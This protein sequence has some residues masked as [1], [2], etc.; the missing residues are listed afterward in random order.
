MGNPGVPGC[1]GWP[2][3]K[4]GVFASGSVGG[5]VVKVRG[6]GPVGGPVV[7][8]CASGPVGGPVAKV[9]ASGLVGG[10][11]AR[12]GDCGFACRHMVKAGFSD[13]AG[14]SGA[15]PGDGTCGPPQPVASPAH[16][17]VCPPP[18]TAAP[19][20]SALGASAPGGGPKM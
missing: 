14:P 18:G 2:M 11:L 6:S 15:K 1:A 4:S 13:V 10:P 17:T 7:K 5:P 19:G 3:G 20:V 12:W 8:V 16:G 9:C